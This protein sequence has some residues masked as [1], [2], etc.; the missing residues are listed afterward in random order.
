MGATFYKFLIFLYLAALNIASIFN[1]KAKAFI[2][3]RK[4]WRSDLVDKFKGN[5]SPVVWF[6]CA[7]LGE[8]EQ[9]RP[10]IEAFKK[11]FPDYKVL[12]TFFSPS[13]YE[14]RKNYNHADFICYLPTDTLSNARFFIHIVKPRMALFV[15]Y[16]FWHYYYKVLAKNNI[17]LLSISSIF[18]PSQIYFSWYG[19]F[20][21]K[22]LSRVN[23]FFV[24]DSGSKEL[25]EN[26]D[27]NNVTVSGDTRFDRV[28][29]IC[30]QPKDLPLV[31]K[32]K[33]NKKTMV[34]GSCWPE[35]LN[36]LTSFINETELKFI[37][38]PH[39]IDNKF[40][41]Q[42][43]KDFIRKTI[44]Y[45][46]LNEVDPADYSILIIDNIGMLSSLYG[47]GE[48][49]YVGGGYGKGLHNIL[50]PATFGIPI[51][52]GDKNIAK[53]KEANDLINLGGAS[54][55]SGYDELRLQFRT[56]NDHNTYEIA[57]QINRDYVKNNVGASDSIIKFS[58]GLLE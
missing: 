57:S 38:A 19:G 9:G 6:H 55:V 1:P 43:K 42:L 46:D 32:F 44:K 58:K 4:N 52:F 27:I 47:Y 28:W 37:I 36:A 51:F 7:S 45:S 48:F 5:K 12:L 13:G 26:I 56:F 50:E 24:Q 29:K 25:L 20:Y 11:E 21:R 30:S 35:D 16:E 2:K 8:F 22:I 17:P 31:S 10:V 3:G 14:V 18:R 54:A 40:L 49:A 53:F 23:H 33:D 34:V 41:K 39:E 15:K